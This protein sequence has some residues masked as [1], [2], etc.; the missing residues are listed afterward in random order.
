MQNN[1]KQY[2]YSFIF[3]KN[4]IISNYNSFH[5]ESSAN[6]V[7]F[8]AVVFSLILITLLLGILIFIANTTTTMT[9]HVDKVEK[10]ENIEL[11]FLYFILVSWWAV[12]SGSWI[13]WNEEARTFLYR[14]YFKI[15]SVGRKINPKRRHRNRINHRNSQLTYTN[16]ISIR[17]DPPSPRMYPPGTPSGSS[18]E[19]SKQS[20]ERL[21]HWIVTAPSMFSKNNFFYSALKHDT[22]FPSGIGT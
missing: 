15:E 9:E 3:R 17:P 2:W 14:R 13:F 7:T 16:E 19:W 18:C 6:G 10:G 22:I 4:S 5:T 11:P 12:L 20:L 1:L 21:N 8:K